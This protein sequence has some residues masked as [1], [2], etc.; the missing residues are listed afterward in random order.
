MQSSIDSGMFGWDEFSF[1]PQS[2]QFVGFF[3]SVYLAIRR[4]AYRQGLREN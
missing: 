2:L 4:D 1:N 3:S